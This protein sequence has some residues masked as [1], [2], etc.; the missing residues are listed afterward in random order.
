MGQVHDSVIF[1]TMPHE[2]KPLAKLVIDTFEDL[3]GIISNMWQ[4]D[5]NLPMTGECEAGPDYGTMVWS[6][7]HEDGQWITKGALP[8]GS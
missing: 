3:P 2:V 7:K 5:F 6:V 1:D 4:V 8:N